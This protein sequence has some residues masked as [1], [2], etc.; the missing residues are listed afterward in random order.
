[1]SYCRCG[2]DSDVYLYA[3]VV[4]GWTLHVAQNKKIKEM[5]PMSEK[6]PLTEEDREQWVRE[7]DECWEIITLPDAGASFRFDTIDEVIE[8]L[9]DLKTKGYIVPEYAY[10]RLYREKVNE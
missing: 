4:G 5:T 1:M 3:S 8:K 2:N 9:N 10:E 6:F 7:W